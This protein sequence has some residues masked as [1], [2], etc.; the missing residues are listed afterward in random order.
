MLK[1]KPARRQEHRDHPTFLL[2]Q[3]HEVG[4]FQHGLVHLP[5]AVSIGVD[6]DL[7]QH[8]ASESGTMGSSTTAATP[9]LL[10][11]FGRPESEAR[12]LKNQ[13]LASFSRI[14]LQHNAAGTE[15]EPNLSKPGRRSP[16][17]QAY[18]RRGPCPPPGRRGGAGSWLSSPP[19]SSAPSHRC[20]PRGRRRTRASPR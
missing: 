13:C 4:L 11:S 10:A 9:A 8:R 1:H 19:L 12:A 6:A 3:R 15:S 5:R 18:R 14:E 17:C 16:C 7:F 20:R 2:C